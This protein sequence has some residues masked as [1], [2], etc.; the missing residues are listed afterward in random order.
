MTGPVTVTFTVTGAPRGKG[1]P[2]FTRAGRCY[3]PAPTRLYERHV[4]DCF[5]VATADR[6]A[7]RPLRGHEG[8]VYMTLVIRYPIARSWPKWKKAAALDG[9]LP[10]T[11]KPDED[12][13][14]KA[15]ADAL[16]GY[17][18]VNDRQVC[19]GDGNRRE[20]AEEPG[21]EVT[22]VYPRVV[23]PARLRPKRHAQ[24]AP[25]T[26]AGRQRRSK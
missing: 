22:L 1:R 9:S 4:R 26:A 24:A 14:R 8:P 2:R 17:A 19:A 15:I 11:V 6:P 16:E 7:L 21:V 10:A 5:L 12:N 13:V 18:Y 20:W 25:A 23:A 3:T